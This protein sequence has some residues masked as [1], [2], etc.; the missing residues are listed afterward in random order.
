[1]NRAVQ[2][3]SFAD[4]ERTFGG[5]DG[6]S[7]AGYA[8]QQFFLNG[9]SEA[10]VVR[11]ASPAATT[12][13]GAISNAVTT[14]TVADTTGFA[15]TGQL[16]VETEVIGYTGRTATTFTG[17]TR[18]LGATSAAAHANGTAVSQAPAIAS[19]VVEEDGGGGV[20]RIA[21]ASAGSWGNNLRATVEY[22]N[23]PPARFNFTVSEVAARNGR[24]VVLRQEQFLDLSMAVADPR[25]VETIVN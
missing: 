17:L 11:V 8:I 24:T 19:I 16:L 25:F 1:M 2:V 4:F 21:A 7:E 12:L 20:L 15:P 6:R 3:F 14:M 23:D 5:L 10:W 22:V 9:G 18:G 13:D